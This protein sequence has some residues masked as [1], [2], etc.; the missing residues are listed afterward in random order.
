L[1]H[2]LKGLLPSPSISLSQIDGFGNKPFRLLG[3]K[4]HYW[5]NFDG[6]NSGFILYNFKKKVN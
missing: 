2:D 4:N 5:L 6:P 1:F 3:Q